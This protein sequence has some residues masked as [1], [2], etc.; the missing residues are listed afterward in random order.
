VDRNFDTYRIYYDTTE[1]STSSPS[2]SR[3]QNQEL[4]DF[5]ITETTITNLQESLMSRYRFCIASEDI[6]GHST[7][8]SPPVYLFPVYGWLMGTV[9]D[10][11]TNNPIRAEVE[12]VGDTQQTTASE[13]GPYSLSLLGNSNY[14]VRY[15][16]W[17]YAS[18]EHAV[19]IAEYDTTFLDVELDPHPTITLFSD[20]FESGAPGWTHSSPPSW[21][22]QWHISTERAHGGTH[23]WKCGNTGNGSYANLLDARL[24]SPV[25][26]S[27]PDEARLFFWMQIEGERSWAYPDS[28]YD[29][30]ILEISA[31]GG[32]FQQVTTM[33]G[34][35][36]TFRWRTGSGGAYTGPMPGQP[37]WANDLSWVKES[38]DLQ[39]YAGQSLQFRFRFGSDVSGTHEGWYVDDVSV[40]A[41]DLPPVGVPTG[42]TVAVE[43][44][45]VHLRWHSDGNYGYRIYSDTS[46]QGSFT[47]LVG[48][49]TGTE[50]VIAGGATATGIEFYI[51]RGWN[52][53]SY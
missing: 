30:G 50:F 7:P 47:T 31:N 49:T 26:S 20:N 5:E 33:G 6:Y 14:T 25:I 42:F 15:S 23:S 22:D 51:V 1:V 12:V 36:Q 29:G 3:T 43:G 17:G 11:S 37:C 44:N 38:V 39:P 13:S 35:P 32:A 40:L 9:R 18:Q 24:I 10:G 52:G 27:I 53:A 46:A 28:A 4:W 16:L 48:E 8:L 41:L 2:I 34:Y 19:Y 45:D 21:G